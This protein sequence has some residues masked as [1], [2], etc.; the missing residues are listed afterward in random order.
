MRPV[1]FFAGYKDLTKYS[2]EIV[3]DQRIIDKGQGYM[4]PARRLWDSLGLVDRTVTLRGLYEGRPFPYSTSDPGGGERVGRS[5]WSISVVR[6][7]R[8]LV[9]SLWREAGREP[10]KLDFGGRRDSLDFL[11]PR[12]FL[13]AW[14]SEVGDVVL[15]RASKNPSISITSSPAGFLRDIQQYANATYWNVAELEVN[16]TALRGTS[17]DRPRL[18]TLTVRF[19][20][21]FGSFERTYTAR[22]FASQ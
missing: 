14:Y 12:R 21:E 1:F 3:S 13:F 11:D 8:F 17:S 18:V 9:M 4:F 20:D 15:H 7:Q 5:E 19:T 6:P 22:V 16:P 10:P 2:Y